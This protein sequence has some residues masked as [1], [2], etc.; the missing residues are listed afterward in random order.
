[1][2]GTGEIV[3]EAN[4]VVMLVCLFNPAGRVGRK[5]LYGPGGQGRGGPRRP[6]DVAGAV[7]P[8]ARAAVSAA[9]VP[10]EEFALAV[11]LRERLIRVGEAT[12][13]ERL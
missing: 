12:T 4:S 10:V 6:T 2:A 9:E 8:R 5:A 3:R 7:Q 11:Q 1:M 13:P